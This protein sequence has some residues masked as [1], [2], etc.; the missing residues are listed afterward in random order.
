MVDADAAL[1]HH[2]LQIANQQSNS[3]FQSKALATEW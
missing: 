3:V 2:L 1:S